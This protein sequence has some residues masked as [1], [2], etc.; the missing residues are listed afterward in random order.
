MGPGQQH[1]RDFKSHDE[2][3]KVYVADSNARIPEYSFPHH[4]LIIPCFIK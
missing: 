4:T 3:K 2:A 1:T